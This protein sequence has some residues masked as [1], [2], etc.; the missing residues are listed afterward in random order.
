MDIMV[1]HF[2]KNKND[3][4]EGVRTLPGVKDLLK[5]LKVHL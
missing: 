5:Y 1:S 3:A 2:E 4:G